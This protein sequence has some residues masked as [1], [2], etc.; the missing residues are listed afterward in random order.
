[1]SEPL[2]TIANVLTLL[3]MGL[4]PFLVILLIQGRF[5]WA[6][7]TLVVAG[8]TDMFDGMFA[9]RAHTKGTLGAMLD[10]VADKILLSSS[11]VTL[12]W[13]TNLV[14]AIPKWLTVLA[15][16]RDAIIVIS[17][18][19]I[20]LTVGRRLFYPSFLGKAS[21]LCQIVIVGV[22]I[23]CNLLGSAPTALFFLY[24]L[25]GVLAVASGVH[26]VYLAA[27]GHAGVEHP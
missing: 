20:N 5:G 19:I 25:A 24:L 27:S 13:G 17:V 6:L 11:F 10:P 18:L 26:Y 3:R 16:S 21:T 23:L 2:L 9:R 15:L 8:L 1:M 7:G 12:T 22:V 4:V 14:A